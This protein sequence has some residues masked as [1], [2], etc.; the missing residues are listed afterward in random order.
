MP[1]LAIIYGHFNL[2]DQVDV[3]PL[4]KYEMT[5]LRETTGFRL[6]R[7]EVLYYSSSI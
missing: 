1:H 5:N 2:L 4:F 6:R 7:E 3:V